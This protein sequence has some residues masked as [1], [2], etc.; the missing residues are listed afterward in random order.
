MTVNDFLLHLIKDT[1]IK[2]I[3]NNKQYYKTALEYKYGNRRIQG[4]NIYSKFEELSIQDLIVL[5]SG[6]LVD[7]IVNYELPPD[8]YKAYVYI[9]FLLHD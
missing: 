4:I 9:E 3:V 6:D 5:S 7:L 8:T 2:Y 1:S